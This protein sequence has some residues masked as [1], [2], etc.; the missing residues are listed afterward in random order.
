MFIWQIL[1]QL[2][3]L[4]SSALLLRQPIYWL[5][6]LL[7]FFSICLKFRAHYRLQLLSPCLVCNWERFFSHLIDGFFTLVII[8]LLCR[9]FMISYKISLNPISQFW[10]YLLCCWSP[11]DKFLA[12]AHIS[13]YFFLF[14]SGSLRVSGL[15]IRSLIHF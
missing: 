9:G 14:S 7:L 8:I 13:K 2:S 10:G 5:D 15:S 12:Y 1:Y 11:F 4:S 6:Y 3:Y